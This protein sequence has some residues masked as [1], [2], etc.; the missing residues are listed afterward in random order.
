LNQS[1]LTDLFEITYFSCCQHLQ[2]DSCIRPPQQ[3]EADL[4]DDH[5]IDDELYHLLIAELLTLAPD[6]VTGQV[7]PD[8][9]KLALGEIAGIWPASI[10]A[11]AENRT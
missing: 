3:L 2:T 5:Y 11:S 1:P 9:V 8:A 4:D 6:P 10:Q 7:E